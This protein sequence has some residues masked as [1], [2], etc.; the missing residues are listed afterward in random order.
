MA[1]S[2]DSFNKRRLITSYFSV[3]VSITLVLFLMGFFSFLVLSANKLANYFKEQVTVTVL[4]KDDAKNADIEQLQKTLSVA[5]FVKSVRFVS[6]EVAAE[7]FSKDIGEDFVTFIGTNP[8]QNTIDL[9]LKAEYAEPDKMREIK[10]E[11]EQ[12]SF[13]TEVVYDQSLVALIHEN[14]NRIG[15]VT[16]IFS[17]L[18][19]FVSILLINASIRLSIYSKRF[20]IKTMQLVGAT[21]SFIRRPFLWTNVRLGILSALIAIVLFYLSLLAIVK[22]YPEFNI[23]M[24]TGT[25]SIVFIS[26]ITIGI[27]ISWLSTY[28]ATQR[29]LNLNTNDLYY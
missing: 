26:I 16:L 9:S 19:T 8:L 12:N 10:R 15:I 14:V 7:K 3:I 22:S 23:L 25:L 11:L 1:R 21:R 17:A 18:F 2:I 24:D 28:F 27:L 13:V 29:F 20:I 6:K 5:S 4:I